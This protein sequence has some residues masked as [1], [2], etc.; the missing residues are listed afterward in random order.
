MFPSAGSRSG[1]II[2]AESVLKDNGDSYV[3]VA[4]ND[5]TFERRKVAL[6]TTFDSMVEVKDGIAPGERVVTKG[7]FQLKSELMKEA[8][9]GGE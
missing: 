4:T 6:G 3:F 9:E 2:P 8:L 7:S 5:T 1:L